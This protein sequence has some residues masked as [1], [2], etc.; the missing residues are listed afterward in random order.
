MKKRRDTGR[1]SFNAA[2]RRL[3]KAVTDVEK[4]AG[5]NP[6]LL[7]DILELDAEWREMGKRCEEKLR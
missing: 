2:I 7:G 1:R 3:R 5:D 4:A 6:E